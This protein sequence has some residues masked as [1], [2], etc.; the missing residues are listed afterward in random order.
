MMA[1][2]RYIGGHTYGAGYCGV[3]GDT[4]PAL[5]PRLAR[6]WDCD[7]GWRVGVLCSYCFG[8][9]EKRPPRRTDYAYKGER[10]GRELAGVLVEVFGEDVDGVIAEMEDMT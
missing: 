7:D 8:D 9:A 1:G 3:C 6:W 2:A 4:G 10:R 5:V